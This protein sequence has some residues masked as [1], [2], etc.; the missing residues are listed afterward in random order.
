MYLLLDFCNSSGVLR[1]F[2]I[3]KIV[4]TII[5]IV[6]PLIVMIATAISMFKVIIDGKSDTMKNT[7]LVS[8]KRIIAALIVFL[9]PGIMEFVFTSL[10]EMNVDF[11]TCVTNANQDYIKK[12][13]AEE[14][15]ER[16][17]N[18]KNYK[19][20]LNKDLAD[21]AEKEKEE[22]DKIGEMLDKNKDKV[23]QN[24]SG[25]PNDGEILSSGTEGEYFAPLQNS[26]GG[27]SSSIT[28]GCSNGSP[29]YHDVYAAIGTPVYAPY[30][31]TAKY[32][33][34]NCQGVLYSFGN[35]VRVFKDDG[36][37]IVYAHFSKFPAGIDM[38][39][40][41]DCPYK[42]SSDSQ[43]GS[44]HC[45]AGMTSSKVAEVQ[46][47]KGQLIGYTGTTGNSLGPH[48]HVEIHE[49]GSSA[50]V[51]DPWAAFGMR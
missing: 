28:G 13:E 15:T 17:E 30:D 1:V 42:N 31:G 45:S 5:L 3:L 22:N 35:Q 32:I 48:L 6:L 49:K 7:L 8:F 44:G 51:T 36:T 2:Y 38:P 23:D 11:A 21:Q 33:Q 43:C 16:E 20:Q 40:T 46:V 9:L 34:S 25:G 29:V 41:K 37:Y 12:R 47:K 4:L 26:K 18:L 19:D 14:K 27:S 10:V 50:C 39:I 24:N